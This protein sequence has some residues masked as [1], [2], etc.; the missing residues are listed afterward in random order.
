MLA[1]L[2]AEGPDRLRERV[3]RPICYE[4]RRQ[5]HDDYYEAPMA[6]TIG[7]DGVIFTVTKRRSQ[8][9]MRTNSSSMVTLSSAWLPAVRSSIQRSD[10][11]VTS[12]GLPIVMRT[13][14]KRTLMAWL[15]I[16]EKR[17]VLPCSTI[18]L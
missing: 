6:H 2:R 14:G 3:A 18:Q 7:R 15:L 13:V 16:V 9:M 11:F 17:L 5:R 12:S 4:P 10:V 1:G 8:G